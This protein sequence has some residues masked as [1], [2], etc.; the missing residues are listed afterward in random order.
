MSKRKF[1]PGPLKK[2]E[3]GIRSPAGYICFF[4]KTHHFHGQDER[5]EQEREERE[6]NMDLFAAAPELYYAISGCMD[7]LTEAAKQFRQRGDT[8]HAT[9]CLMHAGKANAALAKARGEKTDEQ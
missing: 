3:S 1:T 5:Y 9:L 8:G 6:A 4:N 7:M 2:T